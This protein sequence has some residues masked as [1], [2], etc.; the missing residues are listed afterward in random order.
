MALPV[1]AEPQRRPRQPDLDPRPR[2][3]DGDRQARRRRRASQSAR[4]ASKATSRPTCR[5]TAARP[6]RSTPTRASTTRSGR[7]CARR[8]GVAPWDE[9]LA[10][11]LARREPHRRRRRSRTSV[12]IGDVLR[13][14]GCELAVSGPRFPCF[15]FNAA[16]GFNHAAKLMVAKRLVRL[17]PR[18]ARARHARAPATA[19]ELVPGPARGRHRRAVSRPHGPALGRSRCSPTVTPFTPATTPTCS[20]TWS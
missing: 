3:D 20:S 1:A 13:F 9:P 12:C 11:G 15:K 6:R 5:C 14:A 7:R 19:F 17:L 4:S 18:G 10:A 16:M 2:G 8:R